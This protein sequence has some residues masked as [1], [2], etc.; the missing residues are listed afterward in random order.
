MKRKWT[1]IYL[2]AIAPIILV[3]GSHAVTQNTAKKQIDFAR[4]VRPIL[5]DKC[6]ACNGKD[7]K[8]RQAGLRLDLREVATARGASGKTPIVPG[9]PA[10][11]A[12]VTRVTATGPL[13][14]PPAASGKKL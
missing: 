5:S 7:D 11:S 13:V 10:A 14:M 6:F 8:K 9:K 4:D 1:T 12:L 2:G 3:V